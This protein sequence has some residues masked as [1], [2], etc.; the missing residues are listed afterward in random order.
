MAANVKLK[1]EAD[2][3]DANAKLDA[4][5]G[6][7]NGLEK[8]SILGKGVSNLNGG[9]KM[10][11]AMADLQGELGNL[12]SGAGSLTGALGKVKGALGAWGIAIGAVVA[13]ATALYKQMGADVA[14]G[15]G[16]AN[17][18]EQLSA[19]LGAQLSQYNLDPEPII[20]QFLIMAENGVA[21]ASHLAD[22]FIKLVPTL[23]GDAQAAVDL[24]ARFAD[25]E[26]ATGITADTLTSLI[27]RMESTGEV[28]SKVIKQLEKKNIPIMRELARMYDTDASGVEELAKAHQ[29]GVK[30][31][32]DALMHT[33]AIYA[34]TAAALSATTEGSRASME[35]AIGRA[36]ESA[37]AAAN[38]LK[39]AYYQERQAKFDLLAA[40]KEYQ[41]QMRAEGQI[42]G[43]VDLTI[44]KVK[45]AWEEFMQGMI[46]WLDKIG[47]IK[48]IT[49]E[50]GTISE[51]LN[52]RAIDAYD[53]NVNSYKAI[54]DSKYYR[55]DELKKDLAE[56]TDALA[57]MDK[58]GLPYD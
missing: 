37:A 51:R 6:K 29:I 23:D 41:E 1:V 27:G 28:D 54:G 57:W 19:K 38:E 39:R 44:A 18:H 36:K 10:A 31:M 49:G 21:S 35:A 14:A 24:V 12:A 52:N 46:L 15:M 30:Q 40:S 42:V 32:Q 26:A 16:T 50:D 3:K 2:T 22:A 53:T 43:E 8:S 48:A 5:R 7:A 56:F 45:D 11:T 20:Q 4:L 9:G 33:T 58:E 13:A 47:V 55:I 25:V 17:E 34:G